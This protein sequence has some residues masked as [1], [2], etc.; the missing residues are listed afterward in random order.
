MS[1]LRELNQRP[2]AYYPIYRKIT[3]S[4]TGGILLSFLAQDFVLN[5]QSRFFS[6][7]DLILHTCLT[8]TELESAMSKIEMLTIKTSMDD[9]KVFNLLN[10]KNSQDGCLFCG[11]SKTF[12][13]KHHYPVR[14][15]D[16]GIETIRLCPNCHREFH[17]FADYKFAYVLNEEIITKEFIEF[18]EEFANE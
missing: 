7:Q 16:G 13:D 18:V 6:K 8:L 10:K 3:G 1:V 15:K 2:I 12:L 11:Y 4:T 5:K 9:Q 17:M 14:Q